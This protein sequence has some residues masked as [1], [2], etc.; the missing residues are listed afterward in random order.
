[1]FQGTTAGAGNVGHLARVDLAF[2]IR[3]HG[4]IAGMA[5]EVFDE[6]EEWAEDGVAFIAS[7]AKD[8]HPLIW[9]VALAAGISVGT[10]I[11]I[12]VFGPATHEAEIKPRAGRALPAKLENLYARQ[13]NCHAAG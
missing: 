2:E 4:S 10:L 9:G 11:S 6:M 1:V 7:S 12:A 3:T 13:R 5:K 8:N